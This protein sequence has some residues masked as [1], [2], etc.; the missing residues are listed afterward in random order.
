MYSTNNYSFINNSLLLVIT[1][2]LEDL[3][4]HTDYKTALLNVFQCLATAGSFYYSNMMGLHAQL[5]VIL[6][7][8]VLG[9]TSYLYITWFIGAKSQ[10]N[11]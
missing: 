3:I 4:F 8:A 11:E 9:F 1:N 2:R 7:F 10:K 5:V 6:V